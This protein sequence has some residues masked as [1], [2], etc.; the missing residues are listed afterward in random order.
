M[1][2]N[3]LLDHYRIGELINRLFVYTDRRDWSGLLN[4]VFASDVHFDMSAFGDPPSRRPASAITEGWKAGFAGLDAVHHQAGNQL[5]TVQ[6]ER[7]TVHADAIAMHYKAS[8]TKG[9]TRTFV[10]N[11]SI[12]VVRGASGWRIDAF[13]YHLKFMDGNIQLE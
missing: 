4:E 3:E 13:T 5:I 7:A 12:G 11:Y 10:G 2:T 8:A 9:A 6:G 1:S